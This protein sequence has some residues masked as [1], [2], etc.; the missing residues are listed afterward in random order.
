MKGETGFV[1]NEKIKLTFDFS[2]IAA[3]LHARE[4]SWNSA[5]C[6]T[7]ADMEN[8]HFHIRTSLRFGDVMGGEVVEVLFGFPFL[9]DH[10]G[11]NQ[12]ADGATLHAS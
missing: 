7:S 11:A 10:D 5:V 2:Q 6:A 3:V 12:T 4:A 8:A 9:L 1:M